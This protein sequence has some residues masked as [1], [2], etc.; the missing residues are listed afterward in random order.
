[1]PLAVLALPADLLAALDAEALRRNTTTGAMVERWLR[2]HVERLGKVRAMRERIEER[3][4]GG[5]ER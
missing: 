4:A 1:M 3:K 5:S 2:E